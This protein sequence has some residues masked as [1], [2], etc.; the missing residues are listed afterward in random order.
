MVLY[1]DLNSSL[2]N[3]LSSG[4]EAAWVN[5]PL[6][7]LNLGSQRQKQMKVAKALLDNHRMFL[8]TVVQLSFVWSCTFYWLAKK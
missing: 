1:F 4:N 3:L 2:S 5:M 8:Q 6:I 7:D